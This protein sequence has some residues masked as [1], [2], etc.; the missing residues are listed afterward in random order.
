[1]SYCEC[2]DY[3][4]CGHDASA[5]HP[6]L[7]QYCNEPEDADAW[8]ETLDEEEQKFA[9]LYM[10]QCASCGEWG[11][12]KYHENGVCQ[13]C[14]DDPIRAKSPIAQNNISSIIRKKDEEIEVLKRKLDK[15]GYQR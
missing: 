11:N 7:R 15:L 2:E 4:C 3:P 8:F 1:M 13:M 12:P 5:V 10:R 14:L 6:D 9:K